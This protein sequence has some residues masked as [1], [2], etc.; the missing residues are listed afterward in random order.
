MQSRH[1][2]HWLNDCVCSMLQYVVA[3]SCSQGLHATASGALRMLSRTVLLD[4][5]R[6]LCCCSFLRSPV[7]SLVCLVWLV[8]Q[9]FACWLSSVLR[10]MLCPTFGRQ[11]HLS[12]KHRKQ[13]MHNA[14]AGVY[15]LCECVVLMARTAVVNAVRFMGGFVG[16]AATVLLLS[17]GGPSRGSEDRRLCLQECTF[18]RVAPAL[19]RFEFLLA[20]RWPCVQGHALCWG[21][22]GALQ[23]G[24][25][26]GG[27]CAGAIRA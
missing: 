5:C 3:R 21:S 25:C 17:R 20:V 16:W 14:A 23:S 13:S 26:G 6:G 7:V 24:A 4:F 2:L 22:V 18:C 10:S 1:Q 15:S 9:W 12:K 11:A 8:G 19:D 27:V